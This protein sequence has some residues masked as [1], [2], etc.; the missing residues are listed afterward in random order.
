MA[1]AAANLVVTVTAETDSAVSGLKS[2]DSAAQATTQ[3]VSRFGK[4]GRDAG[5]E[6]LDGM[7]PINGAFTSVN[8]AAGAAGAAVGTFAISSIKA[9]AQTNASAQADLDSIEQSVQSLQLAFGAGLAPAVHEVA[10][11]LEYAA[12]A[13]ESLRNTIE[14]VTGVSAGLG[15]V[16]SVLDSANPLSL[17]NISGSLQGVEQFGAAIGLVE[18][19]TM[20]AGAAFAYLAEQ[21]REAAQSL[22][23]QAFV[24]QL[25][26][27]A[28]LKQAA[29]DQQAADAAAAAELAVY[30]SQVEKQTDALGRQAEAAGEANERNSEMRLSL[31]LGSG[32]AAEAAFSIDKLNEAAGRAWQGQASLNTIW[33]EAQ[34]QLGFW[35]TQIQNAQSALDILTGEQAENGVLTEEQQRQY[36]ILT[37]AVGRYTGGVEDSE[38]AVVDAAVAQAEFITKQD[39]LN[40]KLANGTITQSEYNREMGAAVSAIDPATGATYGLTTAQEGV[41][42]AVA[43]VVEKVEGLLVKLGLIPAEKSTD[44]SAPGVDQATTDVDGLATSIS[45]VPNSFTVTAYANIDPALEQLY[46]L[47][48]HLPHSPAKTGPFSVLPN[49]DALFEHLPGAAHKHTVEAFGAVG[50]AFASQQP[51]LNATA[52]SSGANAGYAFASAFN[53]AA[54]GG[55]GKAPYNPIAGHGS[56]GAPTGP[57]LPFVPSLPGADYWTDR[58]G[59][60]PG[61]AAPTHDPW[62]GMGY[63]SPAGNSRSGATNGGRRYVT[64]PV[65][66][67]VDQV[68]N[69][70]VMGMEAQLALNPGLSGG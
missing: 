17:K 68:G 21:V 9:F 54:S 37:G 23:S 20:D 55:M 65:L 14:G 24:D 30:T 29:L 53:A 22:E 38:S 31:E 63:N 41:A 26:M 34:G 50:M 10:L 7:S 62:G 11:Q 36:D 61:P 70:A 32:A 59:P 35:E 6:F 12:V 13:G 64:V 4:S 1:I 52:A 5:L 42:T 47:N 40:T 66:M 44:V 60:K 16:L 49:W 3:N 58:Y 8:L 2:V 28:Q 56:P 25:D 19:E 48:E 27:R 18:V 39:E 46:Y 67:P 51:A 33:G 69:A 43:T 45:E 15:N 57:G